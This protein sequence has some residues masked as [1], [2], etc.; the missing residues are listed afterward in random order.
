MRRAKLTQKLCLA[1][2]VSSFI[3]SGLITTSNASESYEDWRI[4]TGLTSVA[5]FY[6]E[7]GLEET[8]HGF[9]ARNYVETD[10]N[11]VCFRATTSS[12]LVTTGSE[13]VVE[14]T[15]PEPEA[16]EVANPS[17]T[18]SNVEPIETEPKE[19]PQNKPELEALEPKP[20]PQPEPESEP[21]PEPDPEPNAEPEPKSE[22]KA[23]KAPAN[24]DTQK[25]TQKVVPTDPT[26]TPSLLTVWT[27][28]PGDHLWGISSHE[29][30]YNDPYQWP[31]LYKTNRYQIKDAD[32]LQPGQVM[33]IDRDHTEGEIR[34]AI[35]HA[36][37]RGPW[38]LGTVE[39]KDIEYLSR[40]RSYQ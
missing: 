39:L 37:N 18:P 20:E 16:V 19:E 34:R 35:E 2:A 7:K 11:S 23:K 9:W 28:Q 4:R 10:P 5:L 31:L 22:L 29:R 13:E 8:C 1:A 40:E 26:D 6:T 32:L 25:I 17:P 21:E 15:P 33:R 27:V 36:K 24:E 30:V 3:A 38:L 14:V 12:G